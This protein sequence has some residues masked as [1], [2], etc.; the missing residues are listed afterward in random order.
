MNSY[1]TNT[2]DVIDS[3]DVIEAIEELRQLKADV[4]PQNPLSEEFHLCYHTLGALC[5]L[6]AEAAD[7]APDWEYGEQLIR[8]SYFVEYARELAEDCGMVPY[9][10]QWP[11]TCIDWGW[12]ARELKHDYTAVDFDGVTYWVR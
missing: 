5:D 12:A 2:D 6:A 11:M 10:V 7:C 8:D 4:D 3:R 1:P 9:D